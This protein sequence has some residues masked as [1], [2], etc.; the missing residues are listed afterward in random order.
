MITHYSFIVVPTLKLYIFCTLMCLRIIT[1]LNYQAQYRNCNK[2]KKKLYHVL[3]NKYRCEKK[4][5]SPSIQSLFQ[6][7]T[8]KQHWCVFALRNIRIQN[9]AP[10]L[11]EYKN[12]F[13]RNWII[14]YSETSNIQTG[15]DCYA[16]LSDSSSIRVLKNVR[17]SNTFIIFF[18]NN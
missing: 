9:I 12:H 5:Y 1:K 14:Q 4:Q 2:K 18:T 7:K 17:I 15:L 16:R 10:I 6:N 13:N 8:I 11:K 3:Q